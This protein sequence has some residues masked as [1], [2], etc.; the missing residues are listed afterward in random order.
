MDDCSLT[1]ARIAARVHVRGFSMKMH[2][3]NMLKKYEL[4]IP[5]INFK[6]Q[7]IGYIRMKCTVLW[8]VVIESKFRFAFAKT[9][10]NYFRILKVTTW[11]IKQ[12]EFKTGAI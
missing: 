9:Y 8:V 4:E 1:C 11:V 7:C 6:K 10:A 3:W 5:T 12:T 2:Y